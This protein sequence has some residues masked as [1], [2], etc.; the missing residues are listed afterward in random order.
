M[1]SLRRGTITAIVERLEG[2]ARIEVDGAPCVAYPR[3]TGPVALGDEVLVNVQARELGLGSGGF[4]V[5]YANLTRGL[6]LPVEPGAHVMK[7]PY[8]PLQAAVRHAEEDGPLA[9][10][11]A[12]MP[13]VCCSL[14]SQ[15]A[16]VCAGLGTGLRVAY[17]QLPGGALP[18][19]LSDSVRALK[20]RGLVET[21]VAAGACVDGDVQCSGPASALAWGAAQGYDAIVCAIGPGIAG[22]GTTLGHGGLAAAEAANAASALEG[23][24]I[25]AAR[26]SHGDERAR[27]S[28]VSHHTRTA[29]ELCLGSVTVAW[30]AGLA[31]P[32]WLEPREEIDASGW[33]EACA[34]LPLEHMDRGPD[35]DPWFFAAAFAAGALARSRAV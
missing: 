4:D 30:P 9:D 34:D 14:H 23:S 1:L 29:L 16:P 21:A 25:I 22:T 33:R 32:A 19:S 12:G 20:E 26:V 13:V 24:P 8:T 18:V 5:L 15:L 7:L 11:L 31:A 6:E 27:H 2:L 10:T 17:V 35:D 28:G 3:L